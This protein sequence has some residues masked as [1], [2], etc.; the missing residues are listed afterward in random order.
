M[1]KVEGALRLS[2]GTSTSRCG[3]RAGRLQVTGSQAKYRQVLTAAGSSG[4]V[5]TSLSPGCL[6]VAAVDAPLMR[7]SRYS[8]NQMD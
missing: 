4:P 3:R 8:V 7:S 2:E 6:P 5:F 1:S